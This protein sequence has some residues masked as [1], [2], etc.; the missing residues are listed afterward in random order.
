MGT[1]GFVS[2]PLRHRLERQFA[3]AAAPVFQKVSGG[4]PTIDTPI[5]LVV[6]HPWAGAN[7]LRH[8]LSE[9]PEI[10]PV[11]DDHESQ[12]VCCPVDLGR[13]A[14]VTAVRTG[15]SSTQPTWLAATTVEAEIDPSLLT[16]ERVRVVLMVR[17][18]EETLP[19]LRD[20]AGEE[21]V[22][23]SAL[24]AYHS[25]LGR[26]RR[27]AELVGE[28]E[29]LFVITY[30]DL[31]RRRVATLDGLSRSLQLDTPL[32]GRYEVTKRS[33]EVSPLFRLGRVAL[34]EPKPRPPLD[35]R[36]SRAAD[37][38]YRETLDE[39]RARRRGWLVES[40]RV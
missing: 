26:L 37:A 9:K 35:S 16:C 10:W 7:L 6:G 11:A 33:G 2:R 1:N 20:G 21:A 14:T 8:V 40:Q 29:R 31:T 27:T 30:D 3:A 4:G 24:R 36:I 15:R 38:I 5:L 19:R 23:V 13:R 28:S 39:L 12:T 32:T 22:A 18:P 17:R 34:P 25:H